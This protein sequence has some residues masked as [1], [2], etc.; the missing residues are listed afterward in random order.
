LATESST[1]LVSLMGAMIVESFLLR[2]GGAGM[3]LR[4]G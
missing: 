4:I 1:G 2:S 3:P